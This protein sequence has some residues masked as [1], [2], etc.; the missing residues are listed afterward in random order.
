MINPLWISVSDFN[1]TALASIYPIYQTYSSSNTIDYAGILA[2][3]LGLPLAAFGLL[4][5]VLAVLSIVLCSFALCVC[6]CNSYHKFHKKNA[7]L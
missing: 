1:L 3:P 2:W 6:C 5:I 7:Q 4:P